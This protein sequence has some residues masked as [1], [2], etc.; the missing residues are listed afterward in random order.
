[1]LNSEDYRYTDDELQ[2]DMM[3]SSDRFRE[4]REDLGWSQEDLADKMNISV[5]TVY[6]A[7]TGRHAP[8][9]DYLFRMMKATGHSANRFLPPTFQK[10]DGYGLSEKFSKLEPHKQTIV[11]QTMT[12]L[13]D[14]LLQS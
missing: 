10:T 6:R 5:S 8:K 9:I 4:V 1:M 11:I 12:T 13:I 14:T 3:Y 2:E 7:E